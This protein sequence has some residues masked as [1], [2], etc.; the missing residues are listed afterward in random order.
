MNVKCQLT[1][2]Q[3]ESACSWWWRDKSTG[4]AREITTTLYTIGPRIHFILP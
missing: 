3:R 4:E 2:S 1:K